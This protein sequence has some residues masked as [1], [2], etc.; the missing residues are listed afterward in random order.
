MGGSCDMKLI[1][2]GWRRPNSI[3]GYWRL[4]A[5]AS[6]LLALMILNTS[7]AGNKAD[8]DML[9]PAQRPPVPVLV[10]AV[11]Q[12]SIPV[13]INVIGSGEAYLTVNVKSLVQG[14]VQ[15]VYFKGGQYVQKGK[16]LFS[17]DP[18]PFDAALAQAQANLAHDQAQANYARSQNE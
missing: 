3:R 17:I 11:T 2:A 5:A 7:C 15:H 6:A 1:S 10:G 16:V 18:S 13:E 14:E 4:L 12:E 8:G 9:R